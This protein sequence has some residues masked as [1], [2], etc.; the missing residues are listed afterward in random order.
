MLRE[1][2]SPQRLPRQLHFKVDGTGGSASLLIGSKDATVARSAQGHYVVTFEKPFARECVAIASV[3]YGSAGI[4]AS[5]SATSASSVSVRIYDA[6]GADQDA[7][8][9]LV[10]QGFDAADEY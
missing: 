10:V 5:I 4:I 7:D 9:H 3:I 6:A 8:F 2:K 1:I